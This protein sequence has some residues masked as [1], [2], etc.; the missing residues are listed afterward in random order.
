M[1]Q[2][3]I[4]GPE[5]DTETTH[6]PNSMFSNS[7]LLILVLQKACLPFFKCNRKPLS[8]YCWT[9]I[10]FFTNYMC[11][12]RLTKQINILTWLLKQFGIKQDFIIFTE[13][14]SLNFLSF[15]PSRVANSKVLLI[16]WVIFCFF[17]FFIKCG[18]MY[19]DS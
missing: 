5:K 17:R 14:V 15:N 12:T 8:L 9:L 16:H 4:L 19:P 7:Y 3:H 13:D 18:L 10:F 6:R 11:I 2:D 1:N